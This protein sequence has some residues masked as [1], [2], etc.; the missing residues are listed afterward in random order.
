MSEQEY[1]LALFAAALY[2]SAC[3]YIIMT[4]TKEKK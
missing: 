2:A 4:A 3:F 1:A